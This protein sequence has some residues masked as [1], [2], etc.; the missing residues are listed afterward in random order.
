M[1]LKIYNF[2]VNRH[3]GIKERYHKFHDGSRGFQKMISWLYLLWLNICYYVLFCRFLNE[4][5]EKTVNNKVRLPLKE[6]ESALA[7]KGHESI[8]DYISK[9][10]QYDVISFDIFDTLIFR[11]FS[12]P[13]DLFFFMGKE[14]GI[15]D[16][17]RIRM[18]TEAKARW[19]KYKD[20]GQSEVTLEEIWKLLEKEI[21]ISAQRGMESEMKW[22]NQFCYANPFMLEIFQTLH[23]MGKQIVIISD[24]YLPSDFLAKLLEKNGITGFSNLYVS[25]E[26]GKSKSSGSLF[27]LVKSQFP[28]QI[29]MIHVGDNPI[30]D[31]KMAQKYEVDTCYYPNVNKKAGKYRA[32]DMS[33]IIG[34]AYR[35]IINSYLYSGIHTNEMEYEFGFIYG[36]LFTVGYCNFIHEYCRKNKI[37]KVLFLSR[38]GDILKKV[39]DRIFPGENTE[40][41]YWSRAAS[42][43]LMACYN[44]YDYYRRFLYHKVNQQKTLKEILVAM[45]LENLMPELPENLQQVDFLTDGNVEKVRAFLDENWNK[46]LLRYAEQQGAA[47]D[48]YHQV[49]RGCP[50]VCAVDIGW[51]GSG[52]V[53]L[54]YLV[55]KV[56]RFPCQ[57]TGSIAGTNTIHNAEPDASEI[58]L[59]SGELVAYL[60]SQA[61][62]RDLMEKHDPNRG[63]NIFWELLLASPT[64]QF[65]GFYRKEN[66]EVGFHFGKQEEN[67]EEIRQIQ[68]GILDFAAE[69]S[70]HFGSI[71]YMYY[72]SGRDAYA[73]MLVA[74][75]YK[76]KY[77]RKIASEFNMDINV[78]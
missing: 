32:F 29:K 45:E 61:H 39:Y 12:A 58:F 2:F 72:I 26:Y 11:P 56:W 71:S 15:L 76:E 41:V 73:P 70:R 68:Q 22:E 34:S 49:L 43:K 20:C 28:K 37:A 60:Y 74:A 36:G 77:L 38:D 23:K 52:A 9:L 78:E 6:S 51:A 24:M 66:G 7:M 55:Q 31:I 17:K 21:G 27:E 64:K 48:Y 42:T 62:N 3:S 46:V 47:K 16:F 53:S 14:F 57:V 8:Q 69:Y 54:N 67:Q 4:P 18:E 25:C 35:G 44:K 65:K 33:P 19:K 30:S 13:S 63:Y 1:K 50:K 10:S 59:Q 40:Y 5:I 75:G